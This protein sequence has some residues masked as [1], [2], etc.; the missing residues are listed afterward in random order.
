L[1]DGRRM[2]AQVDGGNGHSGKRSQD[3]HFGLGSVPTHTPLR[4][5]IRWRD[6]AGVHETTEQL[7]PGWHTVRLDVGQT[8]RS[9]RVLQ[10][11]LAD[12]DIGCRTGLL[13]HKGVPN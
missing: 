10:D 1:P 8:S 2:T 3:I 9:A 5:E 11:P 7:A 6:A 4:V 12:V 13:P